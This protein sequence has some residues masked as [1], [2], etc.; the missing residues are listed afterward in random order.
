MKLQQALAKRNGELSAADY[1]AALSPI[2]LGFY[3][4]LVLEGAEKS[5][6]EGK[7]LSSGATLGAPV[8]LR[9]VVVK[10]LGAKAAREYGL[11]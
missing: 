6:A 5:L 8:S 9:E 7:K 3:T 1:E 4:T 11:S 2:A 10:Q